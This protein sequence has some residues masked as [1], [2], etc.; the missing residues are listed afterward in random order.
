MAEL[1]LQITDAELA[2]LRLLWER[3]ELTA[4]EIRE[5]LYPAGTPSDQATVQ[6]LLQ[7]LEAKGAV[8]RDRSQ[9]AHVFR[10]L[11]S[12][13]KLAGHEL[14]ALAAKLTDGSLAPL[15]MQAV[16]SRQLTPRQIAEIRELLKKKSHQ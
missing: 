10:P 12:R 7:R 4:R 2:I 15:I 11:V 1:S 9:F 13:E 14:E 5:V 6:K 16:E 8:A 3:K